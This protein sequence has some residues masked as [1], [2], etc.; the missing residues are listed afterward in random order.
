MNDIG[1][2]I[3]RR[4]ASRLGVALLGLLPFFHAV[5]AELPDPT[6]PP[7]SLRGQVMFT[8]SA[9]STQPA[10]P[11]LQS[12][13]TGEGRKPA[14]IISGRLVQLGESFNGMKLTQLTSNGAVLTGPQ[15][16]ATLPLTP[17]SDKQLAVATPPL[18]TGPAPVAP[19]KAAAVQT[20][21]LQLA[22]QP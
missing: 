9:A 3:D 22:E 12:V 18:R 11:V 21:S 2:F 16:G 20:L 7:A 13:I 15:G 5:A 10:V 19:G 8:P 6:R 17:A 4:R 1:L 14:A